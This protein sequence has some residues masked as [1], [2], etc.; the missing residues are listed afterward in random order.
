MFTTVFMNM[1]LASESIQY[2]GIRMQKDFSCELISN[3]ISRSREMSWSINQS[4][5]EV[6]LYTK[7]V[8]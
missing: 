5:G 3:Q 7:E 2:R 6:Q 1:S 8:S 4:E